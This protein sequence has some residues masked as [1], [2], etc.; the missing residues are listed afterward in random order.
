MPAFRPLH[1]GW[2]IVFSGVLTIIAV[3]GLGRF[4]L[5]MLLPSMG[6]DLGLGYSQMGFIGT[7]NFIGYLL[8]VVYSSRLVKRFGFRAVISGGVFLVAVSMATVGAANGFWMVLFAFFV[9]GIGS[10]LANVPIMVLVSH[11]FGPSLRGRAAGLMVSGSGL[12]IMITGLL[13]PAV[14]RWAGSGQGWRINWV[15]MG[16]MVLLISLLCILLI[17]NRP[18]DIGLEALERTGAKKKKESAPSL[19]EHPALP[20]TRIILHLGGIYFFFGFTYVIYVTFV[21]TTLIN[22]YGFSEAVAGRF[23]F[24]FGLLGVFSGPLFG[25]LSDRLGRAK[26]LAIVYGLLAVSHFLLARH[27]IP[28]SVYLSIGIFALSA[29]SIPSIVAAAIGDYLGPLQAASGFATVTLLFGLGQIIGP[30]LA[31]VLAEIQGDFSS[32][33]LLASLLTLVAALL[34][35]TLP[36]MRA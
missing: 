25:T 33:Y 21:V 8:A 35:L 23:W 7:G 5:G 12:G 26:T 3:L 30:S 10:G 9:T 2:I 18:Q 24:W 11:W 28:G 6:S 32:A 17:R 13:I 16:V 19:T 1:Y 14:N 4:S 31:G 15:V 27:P 36:K 20:A 29:W 34:S 22:D